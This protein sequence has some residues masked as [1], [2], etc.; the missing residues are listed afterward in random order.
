MDVKGEDGRLIARLNG[1][2][3]VINRNNYLEMQR[4]DRTRLIVYDQNGNEA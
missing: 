3:F 2:G 4:P 1:N